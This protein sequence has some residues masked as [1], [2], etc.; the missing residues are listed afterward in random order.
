M[1]I[2]RFYFIG[3]LFFV[4]VACTKKQVSQDGVVI[5]ID[6]KQKKETVFLADIAAQ[7]E[8]ISLEMPDDILFG[9][10]EHIK[11]SA[12]YLAL[13]DREQTKSLTIFN[14][15]GKFINQLRRFG[16]GPG[17]YS[18]IM[19]FTFDAKEGSIYT[20][21]RNFNTI[22][23]YALPDL[24]FQKKIP[25]NMYLM[26]MEL[27]EDSFLAVSDEE[28]TETTE[29]G[30]GYVSIDTLKK[31]FNFQPI[32]IFSNTIAIVESSF[33]N[34]FTRNKQGLIYAMNAQ[35]PKIYQIRD[36]E[37]LPLA[38]VDFGENKIPSEYWKE[39]KV[40]DFEEA[41]F[42]P[43]LKSDWVQN[44]IVTDKTIAFYYMFGRFDNMQ[45]AIYDKKNK[46]TT[47]IYKIQLAKSCGVL[48]CALGVYEDS[49]LTLLYPEDLEDLFPYGVPA[50]SPQWVRDIAASLK[51]E[52]TVCLKY[53]IK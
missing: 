51:A 44:V 9:E 33:S 5:T 50:G 27:V 29:Y 21:D 47:V 46:K 25:T 48:P 19:D 3:I 22:F 18:D 40:L 7:I 10:V 24:A 32:D 31:S 15:K 52:K 42:V 4:I 35:Y 49:F 38:T 53:K 1:K 39:T 6:E 16:K 43:P 45:V 2:S 41:F 26:G 20:Y 17:E 14:H 30:V 37:I 34:T 28:L 8:V 23:N 36:T 13:L 12:N 11:T